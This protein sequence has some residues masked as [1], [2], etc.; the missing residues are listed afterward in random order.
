MGNAVMAVF[1]ENIQKADWLLS[2]PSHFF[3]GTFMSAWINTTILFVFFVGISIIFKGFIV[4]MLEQRCLSKVKAIFKQSE[5]LDYSDLMEEMDKASLSPRRSVTKAVTAL[6]DVKEMAGNVEVTAETIKST[7]VPGSSWGKFLGGMLIILGLIGTILGLSEAVVSLKNILSDMGSVATQADFKAATQQILT[8]LS[9]METAFSTTLCGFGSFLFLSFVDQA[10]RTKTLRFAHDFEDYVSNSLVPYFCPKN[11]EDSFQTL[12]T[13]LKSSSNGLQEA[14]KRIEELV[15]LSSENQAMFGQLSRNLHQTILGVHST[16]ANLAISYQ[17]LEDITGH[18]LES[19]RTQEIARKQDHALLEKLFHKLVADKTEVEKL[20]GQLM[21]AVTTL[22]GS[23]NEGLLSV[24]TDIRHAVELQNQEIKRI[25]QDHD[26]TLKNTQKHLLELA[27]HSTSMLDQNQ[28]SYRDEL[29][30]TSS[31]LIKSCS[32]VE[33]LQQ[34]LV[35]SLQ[36]GFKQI[37]NQM[38][39]YNA[40]MVKG[41]MDGFE[42]LSRHITEKLA[43][44]IDTMNTRLDRIEENAGE[45]MHGVTPRVSQMMTEIMKQHGDMLAEGGRQIEK[46]QACVE[47]LENMNKQSLAKEFEH[48]SIQLQNSIQRMEE[49]QTKFLETA[50]EALAQR[51]ESGLVKGVKALWAKLIIIRDKVW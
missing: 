36:D 47:T 37:L 15:S 33:G 20:Y 38:A 40:S 32:S 9:C 45:A 46:T 11:F 18:F 50:G 28:K 12:T 16:Q 49:S 24:G 39:P 31:A 26:T 29:A 4:I 2:D 22:N 25:E 3:W 44:V 51:L 6:R 42:S 30:K 1:G 43:L 41:Y 34:G 23:F 14:S 8:S 19:G 10:F 21:G 27:Q 17:K 13:T 48:I 5:F 7:Y 35:Q